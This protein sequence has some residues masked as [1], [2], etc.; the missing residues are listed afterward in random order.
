MMV[1][2]VKLE[3]FNQ[4][5]NFVLAGMNKT[6]KL[7]I[8]VPRESSEFRVPITLLLI[9]MIKI[10]YCNI[11]MDQAVASPGMAPPARNLSN[12]FIALSYH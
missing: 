12:Q 10:D 7:L 6:S 11:K 4:F 1:V 3:N 8:R 9:F 2:T 5:V